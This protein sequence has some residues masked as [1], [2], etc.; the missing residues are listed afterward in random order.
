MKPECIFSE[1]EKSYNIKLSEVE[2]LLKKSYSADLNKLIDGLKG[3][4][5]NKTEANS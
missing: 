1:A 4:V 5:S 2:K 3:Q